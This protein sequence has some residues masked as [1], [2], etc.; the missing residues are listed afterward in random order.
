MKFEKV[1]IFWKK[2]ATVSK[3]SDLVSRDKTRKYN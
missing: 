3:L 1:L 2:I